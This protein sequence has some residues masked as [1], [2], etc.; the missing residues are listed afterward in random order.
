MKNP[1]EFSLVAL[2]NLPA[3]LTGNPYYAT[4]GLVITTVINKCFSHNL[5]P[6]EEFKIK[7]ATAYLIE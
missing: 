2:V 7:F 6:Q 1:T 3:A 5:S 4:I